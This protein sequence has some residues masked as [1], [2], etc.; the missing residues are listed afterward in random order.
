VVPD[1]LPQRLYFLFN[2][3]DGS[4]H[5]RKI[6]F[7]ARWVP[8]FSRSVREVGIRRVPHFSRFLREVGTFL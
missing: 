7:R 5:G 3:L 2:I 8:H 4:R 6:I 1:L